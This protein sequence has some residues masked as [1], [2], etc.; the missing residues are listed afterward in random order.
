MGAEPRGASERGPSMTVTAAQI[1]KRAPAEGVSAKVVERDYAL[2]HAV[3]AV[4]VGDPRGT[5]V[6]K[7]GTSLRLL[8]FERY[9]YSAD[10]D[11]SVL[12]ASKAQALGL[13]RAAFKARAGQLPR[14]ALTDG[15]PP[16]VSYR[17]PLG[18]ERDI[19]LD[20]ALDEK[21]VHTERK[22][23]NSGW[24]NVPSVSVL[25]YTT[26]EI[27]AEKLRCV[28][29]RLQC[30]DLFD[31][32]FLFEN[33]ELDDQALVELFQLKAR[34]RKFDPADFSDRYVARLV[35][36]EKR[37]D[38]ELSEHVRDA[39]PSFEALE[40]RLSRRLRAAGLLP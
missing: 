13:I 37:W 8:H 28:L 6:F 38:K 4:A 30:R 39:V 12:G 17:G 2:A 26:L 32:D 29:Q 5:M 11:F 9:R 24:T 16:R 25:T 19:K 3:H 22:P 7:G 21:V 14:L 20:L 31:I 36:Y 18:R 33:A 15:D 40:R 10:L 23:L 27:A 35:D 1:T 34:H